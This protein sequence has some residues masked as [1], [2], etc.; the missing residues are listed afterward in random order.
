MKGSRCRGSQ[1]QVKE[2]SL[3]VWWST[4]NGEGCLVLC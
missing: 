2:R 3:V 4:G 1:G